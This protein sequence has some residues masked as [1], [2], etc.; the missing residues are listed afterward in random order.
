MLYEEGGPAGQTDE[1]TIRACSTTRQ[2]CIDMGYP[3]A[4]LDPRNG[5]VQFMHFK[6]KWQDSFEQAWKKAVEERKEPMPELSAHQG[7][8]KESDPSRGKQQGKPTPS[9]A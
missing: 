7:D 8:K 9:K 2:R 5:T 6:I 1:D 3:H 4:Q